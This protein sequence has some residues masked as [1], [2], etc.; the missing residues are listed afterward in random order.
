MSTRFALRTRLY[1][2][3]N[4]ARPHR[5]CPSAPAL[6]LRL[7]RCYN[8]RVDSPGSF[9]ALFA[10]SL[11]RPPLRNVVLAGCSS[12]RI[13]GPA[14]FFFEAASEAELALAARTAAGAGIAWRVIG[15]GTNLLFDDDGYR[16]LILRNR[17][18]GLA[19]GRDGRSLE[20]ASGVGLGRLLKHALDHD[21][22]GLEFAAGI[23]GTVGG[24][25]AGNA[26]AFGRAMADVVETV[27]LLGADGRQAEVPAAGLGFAYRHSSLKIRP[28][29]VLGAV[30]RLAPGDRSAGEAEARDHIEARK[31]KHPPWGTACAGSYFKNPCLPDGT[32]AAAGALLERAGARGMR[33]GDAAVYEGHCNF[34]VNLG[35]ARARDVLD[36]GAALKDKVQAMFGVV[37]E[38][39]VIS[40][41]ARASRP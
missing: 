4:R 23:P 25:V 11:G 3:K 37:L 2:S 6:S 32:R 14:D 41:R 19:A 33:V 10:A 29:V 1:C 30:F 12:F 16:G 8:G 9:A 15:D 7:P 36:L 38:E 31:K 34:I 26:G 5:P 21:L 40:L 18:E 35:R 20:A 39:E 13:G 28:A 17:S 27:R 24:A 22:R